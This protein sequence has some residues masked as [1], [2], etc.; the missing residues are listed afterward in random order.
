MVDNFIER[1][2]GR[3]AKG[4]RSN[5]FESWSRHSQKG[6]PE[7]PIYGKILAIL[8]VALLTRVVARCYSGSADFWVNG[9][10]FFFAL[11]QNFAAGNGISF[12]DTNPTAFRVPLYPVFLAAVTF[13]N[14]E[15]FRIVLAQ[16]LI[17]T[18]TVLCAALIA[19]EMF[20]CGA[21]ITAAIITALYPLYVVHDTALQETSLFTFLTALAVLLL[22]RVRR[23][24]SASMALCA[25]LTLG[26]AVLTRA[27][28]APF[29]VLAPAWLIV[30]ARPNAVP[31]QRRFR[32]CLLCAGAV[33]LAVSPWL[34]RSYWLTGSPTLST[35]S[36]F[37][38]WEANNSYTFSHYPIESIDVS[39]AVA[40]AALS[41]E[42]RAEIKA[43]GPNEAAVDRWFLRKGL[44]YMREHPWQTITGG[45]RKLGAAFCLLPSPRRN[46]WPAL[47]Y[48][49]SYGPVMILGLLGMW[50]GRQKWREHL[51][52]YALFA[53]F[54]APTA[55]FYGH[56]NYRTYLDV[57]W[58]VFAASLL[59][60]SWNKILSNVGP[61]AVSL[62][63]HKNR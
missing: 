17:G 4:A 24:G 55:V 10:T 2:F 43:L 19:F 40:F 20:G 41:P 62:G 15:F 61:T 45:F 9:Y 29:A 5:V 12:S 14:K 36:G 18:G 49:L 31:W 54:A 37:S 22:M 26:A 60:L 27:N 35:E 6:A 8:F 51:I 63:F 53:T 3:A 13:G 44:D 33:A 56:T 42:D 38:L 28:L 7:R 48:F 46:F 39:E 11:A 47:V 57:Y 21:A 25:G 59:E 58:I 32:T 16:S 50:I 30:R 52:F 23:N 34:A 1:L